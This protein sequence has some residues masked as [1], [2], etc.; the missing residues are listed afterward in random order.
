MDEPPNAATPDVFVEAVLENGF[1]QVAALARPVAL[2]DDAAIH[3]HQIQSAVGRGVHVH[4]AEVG[5]GA[6]DE[7]ALHG[8]V[9]IAQARDAVF[10]LD[11]RAADQATHRLGEKQIA[12]QVRRQAVAAKHFRAAGGREVVERL[13]F[14]AEACVTAL[15]IRETH[16]WPH[17]GEVANELVF[18]VQRTVVDVRLEVQRAAFAASVHIP[19]LAPVVLR[20]SPLAAVAGRVFFQRL[21]VVT[22][23]AQA[24]RVVGHVEP[25]VRAPDEAGLLV[26][27][28]AAAWSARIPELLLVSHA[29]AVL[30]TP[31]IDVLRVGLVDEQFTRA[32]REDH[33]REFEV[34]SEDSVLVH[35]AVTLAGPVE[36]DAALVREFARAIDV[37]HVG[38]HLSDEQAAIAIEHGGDG[39]LDVR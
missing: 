6:A 22:L 10:H 12:A 24:P 19:R 35:D 21:L 29:I 14:R 27:H 17:A 13:I 26:L 25:V 18:R 36:R 7:L 1:A 28:V 2:L 15:H 20:E 33:A 32:E 30:V 9:G 31:Q 4:D 37:L 11:L 16:E 23:P 3:V 39:F 8:L 34:V 38:P 5:I